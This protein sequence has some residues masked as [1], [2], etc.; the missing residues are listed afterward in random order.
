MDTIFS[1]HLFFPR[2]PDEEIEE[3]Y[4]NGA[5]I[6]MDSFSAMSFRKLKTADR[7]K[8]SDSIMSLDGPIGSSHFI[9]DIVLSDRIVSINAT[10]EDSAPTFKCSMSSEFTVNEV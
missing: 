1:S 7:A 9:G 6:I 5:R 2:L 4:S 3:V 10:I 8:V